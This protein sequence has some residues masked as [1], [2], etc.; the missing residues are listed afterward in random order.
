MT[1]NLKAFGRLA[2]LLTAALVVQALGGCVRPTG[3]VS[4]KVTLKGQTLTAGDVTFLGADQKPA[5]SPIQPDGTYTISQVAVGPAKVAVTPPIKAASMPRGMKMDPGAIG[6][7]AGSAATA[8]A[9]QGK[10][11]SIPEQY[12][13][14]NK[15]GVVCTVQRGTQEFNIDLK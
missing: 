4:G 8:A 13:D 12:L 11:P 10:P 1:C 15:S 3:S 14:P 2:P 9:S 7:P 5:S 6:G